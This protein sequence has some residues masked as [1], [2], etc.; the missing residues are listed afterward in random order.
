[1]AVGLSRLPKL[2][3]IKGIK[4]GTVAAGIKLAD[5]KDLVV[6]ECAP[7]TEVAGVFTQNRFSAPPVQLARSHMAVVSPRACVINTGYANAGTGQKGLDDARA[8]CKVLA[9]QL[10]CRP[11]EVLPF[12]T[13]VIGGRIPLDTIVN[14]IGNC[15]SALES[16]GWQ[17]AAQGIMTTDTVP[18][19]YSKKFS[20]GG[21]AVTITGIAKGAGM[22][23]P[24][25]ATMLAFVAT[26]AALDEKVVQAALKE[27]VK[28]S[29]N[30]ITVD[31]DTSTNDACLFFATG[32]GKGCVE[33][34]GSDSYREFVDELKDIF[35]LLAQA[36]I[37]DA[38]GATKFIT[39][40]VVNG[41]SESDCQEIAYTVAHS[42]LVKTAFFA[43]DP[44]W[45]RILAAVGRA[46]VSQLNIETVAIYLDD[47][48][49]VKRGAV[50]ESYEDTQ[51]QAVMDRS[52]I[53]VTI[54]LGAGDSETTVW[55]SDLS[56]EYVTINAEYRT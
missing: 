51:G 36:I 23:R 37:R 2:Y 29:F 12:S 46:P 4:L 38:E 26:D 52:E 43:S 27:A 10:G 6:I 56:H 34:V 41:E 55:T 47:L 3:P 40:R 22:I 14:S 33:G 11:D 21:E 32:Q 48:C 24:D 45:G 15:V 5:H 13:G 28:S 35:T 44:N 7:G 42:P 50:D 39:I 25:M 19:G 8:C 20:L 9:E 54:D 1:M 31:G 30:R 53:T 18:K 49:I 17:D 16:S